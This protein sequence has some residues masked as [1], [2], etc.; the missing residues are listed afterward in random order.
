MT[1]KLLALI[2]ALSIG[3]TACSTNPKPVVP[4]SAEPDRPMLSGDPVVDAA[5]LLGLDVRWRIWAAYAREANG[6]IT[7]AEREAIVAKLLAVL[8]SAP[9]DSV[10]SK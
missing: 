2:C 10:P 8:D 6:E 5:T 1:T 9:G 4:L 3:I 7:K